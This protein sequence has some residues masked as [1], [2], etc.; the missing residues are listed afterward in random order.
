MSLAN[1]DELEKYIT[2]ARDCSLRHVEALAM[3]GLVEKAE[4]IDCDGEN[5]FKKIVAYLVN[6]KT[7]ETAC[8]FHE[9]IR[10]SMTIINIYV[11]RA[12]AESAKEKLVIVTGRKEE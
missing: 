12:R 7:V 11:S 6:G 9:E 10:Q 4:V 2:C 3:I 1:I 5:S 8:F